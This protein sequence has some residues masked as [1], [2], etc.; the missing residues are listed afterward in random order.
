MTPNG[1]P[2]PP[3]RP[4]PPGRAGRAGRGRGGGGPGTRASRARRAGLDRGPRGCRARPG[5]GRARLGGVV[6]GR[7]GPPLN[8]GPVTAPP[9]RH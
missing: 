4:S 8:D 1:L 6:A 9:A 3:V 5:A 7:A 2:Q